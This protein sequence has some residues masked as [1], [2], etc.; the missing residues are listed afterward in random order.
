MSLKKYQLGF[1][2]GV[3]EIELPTEKI[4]Q[5]YEG[6][7]YAKIENVQKAAIEAMRNPIGSAPL[8]KVVTKG[9]KVAIV[10]SDITRAWIK[11]SEFLVTIIDELNLAGVSDEDIFIMIA[12]GSHRAHTHEEDVFV[13]G[14][15]VVN[16]IK[17]DAHTSLN[18]EDNVYVGT[19]SH[20]TPAYI[21]KKILEADKVILTGGATVHLMAGFGGGRKSIMPGVSGDETI[22]KN[23]SLALTD[24]IGGGLN[25]NTRTTKLVGNRLHEDMC[26]V[27]K[28]V[29]PCFLVNVVMNAEGDFARIVAGHWYDAWYEGTKDV[30]KIQG[31][32]AK[33]KADL[34]IASAGGFPK[35]INFYQGSKLY[36]TAEMAMKADGIMITMLECEDMMEPQA[37]IGSFKYD[38]TIEMEK[39]LRARFTIPFFVAYKLTCLAKHN[40][41]Y[42]VTKKEHFD[43]VRTTGQ[44]PV[45][46]VQEA[47]EL[48]KAELERRGNKDF[49]INLM[50]HAAN[51]VPLFK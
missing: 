16:R 41:V 7:K 20:G 17:I 40:I 36:D 11:T 19:T 9:D 48:A 51:T 35:D 15:E 13:C 29:D 6:N 32:T 34:V 23:H 30:M 25:D 31:V 33:E 45:E 50:P 22:Q 5:V 14:Q 12:Q 3:Q 27:C 47:Y 44:V 49:T 21:D 4:V 8:Q 2:K 18:K 46:T 38:D 37:F 39:D 42:M 1:G 28:M 43:I 26:E 24:E 10:V